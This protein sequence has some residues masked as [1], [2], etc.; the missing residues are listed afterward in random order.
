MDGQV[1]STRLRH[2]RPFCNTV[3]PVMLSE[4]N[5]AHSR[6]AGFN[7]PPE[8]R[9]AIYSEA[10]E[11][12]N[13]WVVNSLVDQSDEDLIADEDYPLHIPSR[14]EIKKEWDHLLGAGNKDECT[15]DSPKFGRICLDLSDPKS[16]IKHELRR[17]G[18]VKKR[19][20]Q[21]MS[22]KHSELGRQSRSNSNATLERILLRQEEAKARRELRRQEAEA[23]RKEES[24]KR[25]AEREAIASLKQMDEI[26]QRRQKHEE[27]LIQME[28]VRIRKELELEKER[29]QKDWCRNRTSGTQR[30]P[31]LP[32]A[33]IQDKIPYERVLSP[34]PVTQR[35][36]EHETEKVDECSLSMGP[37]AVDRKMMNFEWLKNCFNAWRTLTLRTRMRY[38]AFAVRAEC[39]LQR[40]VVRAW[41]SY[42]AQKRLE[43]ELEVAKKQARDMEIKEARAGDFR[44]RTLK[45][46]YFRT[47]KLALR[48]AKAQNPH[49]TQTERRFKSPTPNSA[50]SARLSARS[51]QIESDFYKHRHARPV[52]S[53]FTRP[54]LSSTVLAQRQRIAEQNREIEELRAAKKYTELL[55]EAR[56][57]A[58]ADQL[59]QQ[60][61]D[62]AEKHV[63][64]VIGWKG[65]SMRQPLRSMEIQSAR[66]PSTDTDNE[67]PIEPP[68]KVDNEVS[69]CPENVPSQLAT[70]SKVVAPPRSNFLKRMEEQ[71]IERARVRAEREERRRLLEEKKREEQARQ[72]EMEMLRI[73]NERKAELAAQ[74]A[75]KKEEDERK[76]KQELRMNELKKLN[77][78]ATNHCEHRCL[79]SYGWLPWQRYVQS[80]RSRMQ[81]A[82]EHDRKRIQRIA[83]ENWRKSIVEFQAKITKLFQHVSDGILVRRTF[84]HLR[85]A[86]E[87]TRRVEDEC[88]VWYNC[89]LLHRVLVNWADCVTEQKMLRWRME[90]MAKDHRASTLTKKC[91][92]A[93]KTY[94]T[95]RRKQRERERRL[96][97]LRGRLRDIVPDFSPP[98]STEDS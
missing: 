57:H 89:R 17:T 75:K 53:V 69:S 55:L 79:F 36:I 16:K 19:L 33:Q 68:E 42:A 52:Q 51:D 7:I 14:Y 15:E 64:S 98:H 9:N 28:M 61:T 59:L 13:E 29:S 78:K 83:F 54:N 86:C 62:K 24:I 26:K 18:F 90:D 88:A 87:Q 2:V 80:R 44:A 77:E 96:E 39:R 8:E 63:E 74:R 34:E 73:K 6:S 30:S 76:K 97:N 27:R 60:A 72:L 71:A 85:L 12:L 21:C 66:V 94:P 4:L 91:F 58:L 49:V 31:S 84:D 50:R 95:L 22:P 48:L 32:P 45:T 43:W 25:E 35:Q 40:S 20:P 41:H 3:R 47:W 46:K 1:S 92:Q 82:A 11:L 10:R 70:K 81:L 67:N 23:R 37:T 93:W 38:T 5:G 56:A 65:K